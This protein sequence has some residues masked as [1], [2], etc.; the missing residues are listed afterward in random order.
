MCSHNATV[1]DGSAVRT[2]GR[3][4]RTGVAACGQAGR[5]LQR[6]RTW[7]VVTNGREPGCPGVPGDSEVDSGGFGMR[8]VPRKLP[9]ARPLT[10]VSA[11][12]SLLPRLGLALCSCVHLPSS[13]R[14]SSK[15][16]WSL[17]SSRFLFPVLLWKQVPKN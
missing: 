1:T 10:T 2:T 9:A 13:S 8:M 3:G 7:G 16:Y 14:A 17:S 12:L 6:Q 4:W 5:A 15:R 11:C